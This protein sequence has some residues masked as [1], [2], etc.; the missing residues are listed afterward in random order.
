MRFRL[1]AGPMSFFL[2]SSHEQSYVGHLIGY[3]L[4]VGPYNET[5][6]RHR[7]LDPTAMEIAAAAAAASASGQMSALVFAPLLS[8]SLLLRKYI[9]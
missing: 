1:F 3:S 5:C 2:H 8:V 4:C 7:G 6:K 9:L